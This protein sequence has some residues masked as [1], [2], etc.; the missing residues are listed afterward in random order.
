MVKKMQRFFSFFPSV[1]KFVESAAMQ[2][3][4]AGITIIAR[5]FYQKIAGLEPLAATTAAYAIANG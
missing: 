1:E 3:E 2:S 4:A 5:K